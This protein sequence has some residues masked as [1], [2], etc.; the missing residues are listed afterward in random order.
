MSLG[1]RFK[2][3]WNAFSDNR[4]PTNPYMLM[5]NVT[6]HRPDRMVYSR[7]NDRSIVGAVYNRIAIDASQI[8]IRHVRLDEEDRFIGDVDSYL[9]ECLK[10][11]PNIDQTGTAFMQDV[12]ESLFDEGVIAIVPTETTKNPYLSASY[13]ITSLRVGKV[14]E[15]SPKKV[16][17]N[18]YNEEKGEKQDIVM[19]KRHVAIIQNPFYSVMNEPNSTGQRLIRKLAI[20]DAI[21]QQSGSGKLDMIIQLPYS[22]RGEKRQAQAK[23][24]KKDIE[25]QLNESKYG[26]AYIDASEHV[27]QLNRPVDNNLLKQIEDLRTMLYSQLGITQE[28]LNGTAN[29]EEMNNYYQRTVGPVLKVIVEEMERKFLTKTAISQKQA[30]RYFRDPFELMTITKI[31]EASNS[32]SREGIVKPNEFRQKL[33]MKP[34]DSP[35]AEELINSNIKQPG[36]IQNAVPEGPPEGLSGQDLVDYYQ[37]QLDEL[38]ESDRQLDELEKSLGR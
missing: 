17:I 21:D 3:A 18:V 23:Q 5:E 14:V 16:K 4:S 11:S 22:V 19:L 12:V 20:L 38:D 24:R 6:S 34:D 10:Y 31:A 36:Q 29:E 25:E 26:I 27:T 15:W 33:G 9:N 32:L 2:R 35:Q 37:Q 7:R 8:P 1:D 30:I 13:D 28:I